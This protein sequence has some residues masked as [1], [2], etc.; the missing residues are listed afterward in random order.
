LDDHYTPEELRRWLQQE[1]RDVMKGAELRIKDATDFV[2]AYAVGAISPEAASERKT[3]YECRWGDAMP[4][5][6]ETKEGMAN[7]DILRQIDI[8]ASMVE[9]GSYADKWLKEQRKDPTGRGKP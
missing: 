6:I 4:R 2:T 8:K 5:G 1:V 7:E 3:T 9:P